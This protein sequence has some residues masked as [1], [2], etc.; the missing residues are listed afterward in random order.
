MTTATDQN[1]I[2]VCPLTAIVPN[3]GVCARHDGHQVAV[4][5]TAEAIYAISNRDPFSG[6]NVL[7]RGLVGELDGRWYVASPLY[8]QRF[9]LASG[10]C[11]DD[12]AVTLPTWEVRV[13]SGLVQLGQRL[14]VDA[15]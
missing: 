6:A 3:T 2:T 13:E 1:W 8:K 7:S 14:D 5:R 11:L 9:G 15:N 4:I 10:Q 12:D